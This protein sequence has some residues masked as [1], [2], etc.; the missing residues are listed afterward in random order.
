MNTQFIATPPRPVKSGSIPRHLWLLLRRMGYTVWQ[1]LVPFNFRPEPIAAF[2]DPDPLIEV[3]ESHVDQCQ[4]IFDQ[5]EERR[6]HLEQKAQ[7]TFSLMVFL[8]PLLA[9]LFV[10]LVSRGTNSKMLVL[11]LLLVCVS[12]VFLLLGFIAAIRAVGVKENETLFLDSV[13]NEEGK[14]RK[15]SNAFRAHGLLYCASMNTAMNDHLAQFVKG[16][17]T[18]TAAAVLVLLVAAV[19]TSAVYM[20]SPSSPAQTSIIGPVTISSPEFSSLRGDV[21]NL[22][23]DIQKLSNSKVSEDEIKL[24]EEKIVTL[25]AK[26]AE[27]QK[28]KSADSTRSATLPSTR[29][30]PNH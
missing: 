19:P 13:L 17:H 22:R 14:F 18:M 10:F 7:A 21:A 11:T 6:D 16:A 9:S 27:L 29:R 2:P 23:S 24:L 12:G 4:W 25:D 5:A 20:R 3:E 26:L 28:A 30:S 8:V 1:I 15:Y